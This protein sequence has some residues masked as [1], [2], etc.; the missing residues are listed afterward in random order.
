MRSKVWLIVLFILFVI[1][2]ILLTRYCR[3]RPGSEPDVSIVNSRGERVSKFDVLDSVLVSA[4]NL[5]P[6]EHYYI[7]LERSDGIEISH[8]RL[9][10]DRHGS[11]SCTPI[12]YD[13]GVEYAKG[14]RSGLRRIDDAIKYQYRIAISGI[15]KKY[16]PS[17]DLTATKPFVFSA[18]RNGNPLNG[19]VKGKEDV[20]VVGGNYP[21]GST[22]RIYL[23]DDRYSWH[24]GDALL[25]I[26][27]E[28][29]TISLPAGE[30]GFKFL[31]WDKEH[32]R[33]GSYDIIADF[34]PMD[35]LYSKAD[36]EPNDAG[37]NVG[38]VVQ[39]EPG[40]DHIE[41]KLTC[42]A[43]S[44]P[45]PAAPNPQYKDSFAAGEEVWVAVNPYTQGQ[46]YVGKNARIYVINH[47]SKA[48]YISGMTLNDVSGGYEETVIQP[49][50]ANVN[51]TLVWPSPS[52][53]KYDVVVDFEPFG[54]YDQGTDI[55][56]MLD[57]IGLL[58]GNPDIEASRI[59]FNWGAGS[60]ATSLMDNVTNALVPVPEW[61]KDLNRNEPAAYVRGSTITVKAQFH[62]IASTAPDTVV[63][64]ADIGNGISLAPQT[65]SFGGT[66]NSGYVSFTTSTAL[67]NYVNKNLLLWQWYFAPAPYPGS[68]QNPM[69]ATSH[70]ICTTFKTPVVNPAYKKT[71]LWT[72]EWAR[73]RSDEKSIAD[74]VIAGLPSSGLKYGVSGWDID[75][76]L[77]N[78][79]G[80]CGGWSKMFAHMA[81]CQGVQIEKRC[82]IL[83]KDSA[84]SPEVKWDSIVIK[85]GGLNQA[86]PTFSA[87]S[88]QDVDATYPNPSP[89]DISVRN[90]KRYRFYAP[91][92]GHCIDFLDYQGGIY[93]YDPSFGK[94]PFPNTF[95]AIPSGTTN[96]TALTNFRNFYYN[97]AIDYMMGYIRLSDGT[98]R[99]L[100]IRTS[101]IPD[102]RIPGNAS[103][104]EIHYEWF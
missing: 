48:D 96:G 85:N 83:K 37:Y 64:W 88:Y 24:S 103:S 89:G 46:N 26:K 86:Q 73:Y 79:G 31:A 97:T 18:D 69:N 75:Y 80:M 15:E 65:V 12:W 70:T 33:I 27:G 58:V 81:G 94:G 32:T 7:R 51:Y 11:I 60:G 92:D 22:I 91:D 30:T 57:P 3:E 23:V 42:L 59:Q 101:L 29:A 63:A 41:Q 82:Y 49:G 39:D 8:A 52:A 2:L 47:L 72:S 35:G 78:G 67:P 74:A 43:P 16:E 55:V 100:T 6:S 104:Y 17:F 10:T 76:M 34:L 19:F 95:T 1:L 25:D 45:P 93:L 102:L 44:P 62:K 61:D 71:M 5:K 54:V 9:T 13:I 21:A 28:Y 40:T 66:A 68:V 98:Y 50:C 38:F 36:I 4:G 87:A 84:P 99:Y 77:D 90:E 53:G 56:D 20:Y 14:S